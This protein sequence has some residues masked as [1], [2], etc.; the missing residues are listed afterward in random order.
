MAEPL[1]VVVCPD[2]FKG[3][4]AAEE[5]AAAMV[6]GVLAARPDARVRALPMA[7]GGEGTAWRVSRAAG[8]EWRQ[9]R[10]TGPDGTALQAGWGLD[11]QGRRAVLDVA[12]ACG[13]DRIPAGRRDPWQLDTRGVGELMRAALDA[14][15]RHLLVGLGGS[16]TVDGGAGLLAA[17]GVRFRDA[18]GCALAPHPAALGAVAQAD[19]AE[20]DP[21]LGEVDI[22][23]LSDV[24][25]PLIGPQGAAA[26]F[27]P[28]KG[29]AV[30][31]VAAMDACM[32]RLAGAIEAAGWLRRPVDAPGAGAA[33]GLGFA[34]GCVLGGTA[35]MGAMYVAD[36]I[37]L[38][39]AMREA[40]RVI[41]GE[42]RLDGQ[43]AHGKVVA[44]VLR[45]AGGLGVPVAAVAGSVDADADELAALGLTDAR[46]LC[47]G[48]LSL[49]EAMAHPADAIAARTRSLIEEA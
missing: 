37:G 26:V 11:P 32:Q 27:G 43:T 2:S 1:R 14:G 49:E 15:A 45:R 31:D 18:D 9:A 29:L 12:A 13:L 46:A 33:G 38:D 36:L 23:L 7:D 39:A 5:V 28:Q 10:V 48:S 8:W 34:L 22:T 24:D 41:T 30:D 47:D 16:G 6:R 25:N 20:L 3:S 21:C 42:G 44:E 4:L 19:F 17:L 35:R 40:D